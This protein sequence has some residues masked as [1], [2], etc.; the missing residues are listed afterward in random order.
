MPT[1]VLVHSLPLPSSSPLDKSTKSPT[2]PQ[3]KKKRPTPSEDGP[4]LSLLVGDFLG[5]GAGEQVVV[6]QGLEVVMLTDGVEAVWVRE[7]QGG[8]T[9]KALG[10][11]VRG[12]I[13]LCMGEGGDWEG[14]EEG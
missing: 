13:V 10:T 5:T 11:Q 14:V 4:G 1:L 12:S 6:I 7:G 3:S 9:K 8:L 2:P